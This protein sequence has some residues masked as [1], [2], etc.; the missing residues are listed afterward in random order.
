MT[1]NLAV[2]YAIASG[3][4]SRITSA[5]PKLPS[6]IL[7]P[8]I[9]CDDPPTVRPVS[10]SASEKSAS[11]LD[12]LPFRRSRTVSQKPSAARWP[13]GEKSGSNDAKRRD[14]YLPGT[15]EL[16]I[17]LYRVTCPPHKKAWFA[18]F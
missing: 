7:R 17:L 12:W 9:I 2:A 6:G 1:T 15:K 11:G 18:D 13:L 5:V 4:I 3:R 14:P 16:D 10:V 8:R